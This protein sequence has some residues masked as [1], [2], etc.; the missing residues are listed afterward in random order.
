MT[1]KG[2][3]TTRNNPTN[4]WYQMYHLTLIQIQFRHIILQLTHQTHQM[5]RIL[6]YDG[7]QMMIIIKR[8]SKQCFNNLIKRCA[9]LTLKLLKMCTILWPHILNWIRIHYSAPYL[10][11]IFHYFPKNIYLTLIR[12]VHCVFTI[13]P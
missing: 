12:L 6:N 8:E 2:N 7:I 5:T 10:F 9:H 11:S 3:R 13:H 1:P 4:I